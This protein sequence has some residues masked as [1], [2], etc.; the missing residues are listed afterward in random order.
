MT[1]P[2]TSDAKMTP[3][4]YVLNLTR[5]PQCRE[6]LR[7]ES[8]VLFIVG[9]FGL[10]NATRCQSL[11]HELNQRGIQVDVASS[12]NG[13]WY[14]SSL[15]EVNHKLKLH[16]LSYGV[17]NGKISLLSTF[18]SI[19]ILILKLILNSLLLFRF[20]HR[21]NHSLIIIDS[22]YSIF[23]VK[24]LLGCQVLSLNNVFFTSQLSLSDSQ[25]KN[26]SNLW[27][28]RFI[29]WLDLQAQSFFS[30]LFISPVLDPTAVKEDNQTLF[31][32]PLVRPGLRRHQGPN[33]MVNALVIFS[34]SGIGTNHEVIKEL[35]KIEN[36]NTISILGFDGENNKKTTYL[37]KRRDI[38]E[39]MARADFI[40]SAGG[41]SSLSEAIYCRKPLIMI[42][43]SNHYEQELNI[44][45]VEKMKLGVVTTN[46][47]IQAA[48]EL[49]SIEVERSDWTTGLFK[50][51]GASVA[52]D[53]I[54]KK[55]SKLEPINVHA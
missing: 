48:Y 34:G 2:N 1:S 53:F 37:G 14:L 8:R 47:N 7:M 23:F 16:S 6:N 50:Q 25:N 40:V 35:E 52:V 13:H 42:P 27:G 55:C 26:S 32:P 17:V 20:H 33:R 5:V 31:C 9:G 39:Y 21:E 51:N 45:L 11:I 46:H 22:E 19:P 44:R 36:L 15:P 38:D 10:G 24:W 28:T 30:D 41:F 54:L 12:G 49:L 43:I 3:S 18:I 29:E 4:T